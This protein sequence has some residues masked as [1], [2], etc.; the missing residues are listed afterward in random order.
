MQP[1]ELLKDVPLFRDLDEAELAAVEAIAEPAN[2]VGGDTLFLAGAPADAVYVI[3]MGTI[4][5]RI[6]G[7]DEPIARFGSRQVVGAG[8]IIEPQERLISAHAV[9][10]TRCLRLPLP[11]LLALLDR[12][13]SLAIKIHRN[14][15]RQF[16]HHTH[17]LA[18]ELKRPYF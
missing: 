9:E 4:E 7:R 5:A 10:V 8:A 17:E 1:R 18:R 3:G 16:L 12:Q 6:D 2:L 13:P 15:A 14:V 11:A